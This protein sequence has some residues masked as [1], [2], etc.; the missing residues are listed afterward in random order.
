LA[1]DPP[2]VGA[3]DSEEARWIQANENHAQR[4]AEEQRQAVP[5]CARDLRLEFEE[6]GLP[7][8]NSPQANLGAA[9]ARLQ[10]A[11]PS[12]EANAAMAYVRVA[13]TLVEERST[14]S[15]SV[16]Y[17]SSQHSRSQF[18]RPAH[19]KLPTIQEKVNQPR[20]NVAPG[21]DLCANLNKN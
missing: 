12:P 10:L 13:T 21:I 9:L 5:P 3:T 1:N 8:F 18:N 11:N 17:T 16:A 6:A 19:S 4:W 14:A 7:T 15:K 2:W 20:A